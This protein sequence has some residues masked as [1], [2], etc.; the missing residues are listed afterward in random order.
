MTSVR[1]VGDWQAARRFLAAAPRRFHR[2]L[3][4][5]VRQEAL[6]YKKEIVQGLTTGQPGGKPLAPLAESTLATRR[7]RG[8]RGTKPLIARGDLRRSITLVTVK[9]GEVFVGILRSARGRDGQAL[10]N[11]AAVQEFGKTVVFRLTPK[12][13]RFLAMA[14]R[15]AGRAPRGG[16]GAPGGIAIVRI[17]PRPFFRPVFDKLAKGAPARVVGR[18]ARLLAGDIGGF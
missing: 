10:V 5:A 2:A 11:V 17:P 3:D 9:P 1:K 16:G 13:R 14:L 4:Q 12:A 18:M 7:A 8:L 15:E 6:L